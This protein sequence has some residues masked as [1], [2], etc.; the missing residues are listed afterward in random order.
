[1]SF[2]A[3]VAFHQPASQSIL[4]AA[5]AKCSSWKKQIKLGTFR[6]SERHLFVHDEF[7]TA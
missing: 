2:S 3:I 4:H 6:P 1:M 7:P 5:R